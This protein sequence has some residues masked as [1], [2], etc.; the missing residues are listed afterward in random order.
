[1]FAAAEPHSEEPRSEG[2]LAEAEAVLDAALEQGA[3]ISDSRQAIAQIKALERLRRKTAALSLACQLELERSGVY[4]DD[5]HA[6]PKVMVR[7][8]G[9]LSNAEA[10]G[11][12]KQ[13]HM[14][15]S[16]PQITAAFRAGEL[17]VAQV[18]LL[19]RIH[20]NPRVRGLMDDA[21]SWFIKCAQ[22]LPYRD[23]EIAIRE[24]ERLADLDGAAQANQRNHERRNATVSHN[25]IDL[26]WQL[27]ANYASLQGAS[28]DDI[29]SHYIAAERL[30]DWEQARAELGATATAAD[31]P[32]SE[33]QRRADA[34]WQ[35]FQDAAG[36]DGSCAPPEFVHDIIWDAQTFETM[37]SALDPN[38]P[39]A[40]IDLDIDHYRCQT[41]DGVRLEPLEAAT[42]ALVTKMRRVVVDAAGV[43][44]D[45]GR[46]RRFT[47]SARKAAQ[48]ATTRCCWPGC[49]IPTSQCQ[50]DHTHEHAKGGNTNPTN[51]APLCGRHNR[52]R[53]KGFTTR[54][55]PSG[56]WHTHRPDQT[57]IE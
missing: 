50:I 7:H 5:G 45:L 33:Q 51:A 55:D 15:R 17:G 31:L 21:Q 16:L 14:C 12:T 25:Q 43:V 24:W 38:Q 40:F 28:I 57:Q 52:H 49:G 47:G 10:A 36:A 29:F 19:G 42:S 11:R 39:Q 26:S 48:L 6:S 41:I 56:Q 30:A 4:A 54:R 53:Q 20:A 9:R 22:T 23:F 18:D 27:Q 46:K 34:L 2:L 3:R 8:V 37:L 1:M 35:I 32:R 13:S 44:T